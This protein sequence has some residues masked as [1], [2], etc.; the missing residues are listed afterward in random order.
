MTSLVNRCTMFVWGSFYF[1]NSIMK[2][3]VLVVDVFPLIIS[4]RSEDD[5]SKQK[6]KKEV[7][8]SYQKSVK[9][10]GGC[11]EKRERRALRRFEKS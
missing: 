8:E 3:P 7:R 9:A 4:T 2:P 5:P 1:L 11:S 10:H 6:S